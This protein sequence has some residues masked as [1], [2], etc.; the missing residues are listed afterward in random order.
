VL[1][2]Q[3]NLTPAAAVILRTN[4][5]ANGSDT[6]MVSFY[7]D[8]SQTLVKNKDVTFFVLCECTIL[9]GVASVEI[10]SQTHI[11]KKFGLTSLTFQLNRK[12][13]R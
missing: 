9:P 2:S 10:H 13:H 8:D 11:Q 6:K 4:R 7:G 3:R 5:L 1:T 12:Q